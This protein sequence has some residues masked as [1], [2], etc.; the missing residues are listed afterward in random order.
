MIYVILTILGTGGVTT[1]ILGALWQGAKAALANERTL[2]ARLTADLAQ[3]NQAI[4]LSEAGRAD[5]GART[6][7]LITQLKQEL[8]ASEINAPQDAASVRDRLRKLLVAP[9]NVPGGSA[10]KAPL[11]TVPFG[12]ASKG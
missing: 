12:G 8:A 9:S 2:N 10:G 7:A 3:A 6:T 11:G 4:Q 1:A 5:E